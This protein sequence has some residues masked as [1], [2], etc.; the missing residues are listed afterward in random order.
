VTEKDDLT[1]E[2]RGMILES[3]VPLDDDELE[4]D[5]PLVDEILDSL[6]IAEMAVF[7]EEHIGRPLQPEE[8]TRATFASVNKVVEFILTNS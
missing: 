8:E 7:I 2:L 3:L 4:N 5:S 6:G 1:R